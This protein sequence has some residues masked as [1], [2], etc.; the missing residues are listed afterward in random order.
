MSTLVRDCN[1]WKTY[2]SI[3]VI[4][5]LRYNLRLRWFVRSAVHDHLQNISKLPI[6][7]D[8]KSKVVL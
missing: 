4:P 7:I 3:V 5:S 8:E 2:G 6:K 1:P